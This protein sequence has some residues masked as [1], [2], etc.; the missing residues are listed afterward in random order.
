MVYVLLLRAIVYSRW[1]DSDPAA[2]A[3][4]LLLSEPTHTVRHDVR[5]HRLLWR[6]CGGGHGDNLMTHRVHDDIVIMLGC[7]DNNIV[8]NSIKSTVTVTLTKTKHIFNTTSVVV[9]HRK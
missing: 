7:H 9:V 6:G 5:A 4:L 8:L 3:S 1:F 2:G